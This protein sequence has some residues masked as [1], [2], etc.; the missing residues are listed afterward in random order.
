[1]EQLVPVRIEKPW[2]YEL[3]WAKTGTYAGKLLHVRKGEALSLQYHRF[4]DETM[5]LHLGRVRLDI[6]ESDTIVQREMRAGD[7][8]HVP[9]WT[10]HRLT[11]LEDSDVFEVSTPEL[12][13]VVR[14][15]DRYGR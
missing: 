13:D 3:H 4:K 7:S 6:Q 10:V 2:G 5:Y 11:A 8:V 14:L 1:V 9:P 12:D 15:E